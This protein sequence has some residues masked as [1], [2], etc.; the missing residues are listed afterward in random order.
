MINMYKWP[1]SVNGQY[2][3]KWPVYVNGQLVNGQY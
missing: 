1:N 2:M 3:Y